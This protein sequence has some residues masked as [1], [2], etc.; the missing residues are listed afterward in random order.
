MVIG[1]GNILHG[2]DGLGV[3]TI[4]QLRRE[5]L[6][7]QVKILDGGTAGID[8]LYLLEGAEHALFV[9]SLDAGDEPGAMFRIPWEVLAD[10]VPGQ[11]QMTSLHDFNLWAVLSLADKLGKMPSVLIFGIQPGNIE[12]GAGLSPSVSGAIPLLVQAIKKE[13]LVLCEKHDCEK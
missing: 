10:D 8:L 4:E 12:F 11:Q 5:S 6:P 3:H 1:V 2:D 9:D 13:I 7:P